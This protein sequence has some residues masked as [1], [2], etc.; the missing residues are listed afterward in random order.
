MASETQRAAVERIGK[1]YGFSIEPTGGGAEALRRGTADGGALVVT[2]GEDGLGLDADVSAQDWYV[3]RYHMD[4]GFIFTLEPGRLEEV[5]AVAGLLPPPVQGVEVCLPCQVRAQEHG[6]GLVLEQVRSGSMS[7]DPVSALA[8]NFPEASIELDEGGIIRAQ[9]PAA[10]LDAGRLDQLATAL[11]E[12]A[13]I[14][15]DYIP[16]AEGL[17]L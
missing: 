2:A 15:P 11:G 10:A 5:L 16:G 13:G 3:G 14:A 7:E 8:V 17:A 9:L 12:L 1:Q 4:S 6:A